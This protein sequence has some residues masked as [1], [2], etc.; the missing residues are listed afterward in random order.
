[1]DWTWGLHS[2]GLRNR[3]VWMTLHSGRMGKSEADMFFLLCVTEPWPWGR[4]MPT[5]LCLDD[6]KMASSETH[7]FSISG[8]LLCFVDKMKRSEFCDKQWI[9]AMWI[10]AAL[11]QLRAW[12]QI[13]FLLK[14]IPMDG[15]SL[16]FSTLGSTHNHFQGL[17]INWTWVKGRRENTFPSCYERPV[18]H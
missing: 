15:K 14:S 13:T 17:K 9:V 4:C 10:T 16:P 5:Q 2:W 3:L 12:G 8:C 11:K 1:M 7:I 6:I 18:S